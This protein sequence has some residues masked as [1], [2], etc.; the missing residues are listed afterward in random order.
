MANEDLRVAPSSILPMS[1]RILP[2][3]ACC[4]LIVTALAQESTTAKPKTPEAPPSRNGGYLGFFFT[5]ESNQG[6]S[7]LRVQAVQPKSC[8]EDLGLR[9]GDRI[10]AVDGKPFQNGDQF[11]RVLW[12]Q[13]QR[14]APTGKEPAH[15]LTVLRGAKTLDLEGG[16][17][18]LDARPAVGDQAPS[19]ELATTDGKAKVSL[20]TLLA[21]KKPVVLV[22]GSY[23]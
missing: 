1:H 7:A 15:S 4:L 13:S 2:A 14:K 5:E 8:A 20:A 23:T 18:E 19:F 16:L 11:M 10:Q 17:R 12:Y 22:F 9:A 6:R 3:F 21:A